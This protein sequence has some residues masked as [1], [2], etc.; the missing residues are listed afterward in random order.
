MTGIH[1]RNI[2]ILILTVFVGVALSFIQDLD[3]Q[4]LGGLY[5]LYI[6]ITVGVF[7]ILA[8]LFLSMSMKKERLRV[9]LISMMSINLI[10]GLIMRFV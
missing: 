7:S 10:T 5:Y 8:Y 3:S 4:E 1:V 2:A 6:P 9:L